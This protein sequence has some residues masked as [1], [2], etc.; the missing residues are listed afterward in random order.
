MLCPGKPV[1]EAVVA[2]CVERV[3][4]ALATVIEIV[5]RTTGGGGNRRAVIEGAVGIRPALRLRVAGGGEAGVILA[6]D[7]R[8]GT[9]GSDSQRGVV[10]GNEVG[11]TVLIAAEPD[12]AE[13]SA[14][15]GKLAIALFD[16]AVEDVPVANVDAGVAED[17]GVGG[18]AGDEVEP[19]LFKMDSLLHRTEAVALNLAVPPGEDATGLFAVGDPE[20]ATVEYAGAEDIEFLIEGRRDGW[21]TKEVRCEN[22]GV[23]FEGVEE[24]GEGIENERFLFEK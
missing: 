4:E 3:G 20:D 12:D 2:N 19:A 24:R 21:R 15:G 17:M 13:R 1:I 23:V 22:D 10:A 14:T 7:G 8:G 5:K 6:E 11:M 9:G 18:E 16:L